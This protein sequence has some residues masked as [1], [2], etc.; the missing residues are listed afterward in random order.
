MKEGTYVRFTMNGSRRHP[1][2]KLFLQYGD[3][4]YKIIREPQL[5]NCVHRAR[6]QCWSG[7]PSRMVVIQTPYGKEDVNVDNIEEAPSPVVTQVP[8]LQ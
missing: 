6:G 3:R 1:G 7:C 5:C 8:A 4:A 2:D